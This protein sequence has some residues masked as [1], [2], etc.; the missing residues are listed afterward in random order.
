[1]KAKLITILSALTLTA[2][3]GAA[4]HADEAEPTLAWQESGYVQEVVYAS[5]PRWLARTA[6]AGTG[7]A[8]S[9][10]TEDT[11]LAWQ[12]SGYQEE[13]VVVK[14]SRTEVLAAAGWFERSRPA[15]SARFLGIP[16]Q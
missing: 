14:A 7:T 16:A 13:V 4:A 10:S 11:G 3:T 15:W 6:P 12:K 2:I 9:G 8:L 1:M 5:A